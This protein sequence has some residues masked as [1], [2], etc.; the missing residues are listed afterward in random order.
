MALPY[1]QILFERKE[2]FSMSRQK[3]GSQYD[4]YPRATE[5]HDRPS[6]AHR[7]GEE[8]GKQ[9]HLTGPELSRQNQEH[10][11]EA[12]LQAQ[13]PTVGHGIV[14]FGHDDIAARAFQLWLDRGSP[15]GSPE[16]DW[17]RAA[18]ELRLRK[19]AV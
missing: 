19:T 12:H 17:F 5:L 15:E 16:E 13:P 9:D 14:A 8:Q 11:R 3:N 2:Q 7:V 1:Q 6:H 4:N 18:E 10:N